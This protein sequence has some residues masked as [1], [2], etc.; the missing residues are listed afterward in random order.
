MTNLAD[1]LE[2]ISGEL[3][4]VVSEAFASDAVSAMSDA[5]ILE[6]MAAAAG[7]A[8]SAEALMIETTGEVDERSDRATIDVRM[9]TRFGCRS[10]IE[11]VQRTTRVS[12]HTASDFLAAGRAMHRNVAPSSGEILPSDLPQMREAMAAGHVGL[13]AVMAVSKP[14]LLCS[15]GRTAIL[16][17]DEEL[18]SSARGEGADAAPPACAD[19]L[20]AL[21]TVWAMYL[22]QDGAEPRERQAMR[23]RG[24][25]VGVCRDH[26]VPIRGHLLP[27]VA[28]QLQRIFD[29]ILNPKADGA[30]S[31][32]GPTFV[33][34]D[35]SDLD[36]PRVPIA[37]TRSR[38]QKQ[39]DALATALTTLAASGGLPTLGGAAPTLVVSVR[40]EDVAEG[41]GFAHI[42]GCDEPISLTSARHIACSGAVQRILLSPDGRIV[43]I[44]TMERVFNHHQRRAIGVRDGGCV[45]PGCHV[46]AEWCEIHH[47][48][49]HAVG[50]ATDTDNGVLLC[51][52]HHR[53]IDSSGWQI[54]MNHGVPEV[55]GPSWWDS[56]QRWRPVTKSPTR[57]R[58]RVARRM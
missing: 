9:T 51:W 36:A 57:M 24:V 35:V 19:D 45:I 10:V 43:A 5:E 50:G 33:E 46:S 54:R 22:D 21:A 37:D 55:R 13:D 38:A 31:P 11:L 48:T 3:S 16:A 52:F 32:G 26:L 8:R 34:S 17:A 2:R 40:A 18:A 25:T 47:V 53:T 30:S 44:G 12:K 28:G 7:V 20:R 58:E 27:E 42:S 15:A 14:L 39:H 49:G 4:T 41:R 23:K 29:S 1:A 6:I 56:K